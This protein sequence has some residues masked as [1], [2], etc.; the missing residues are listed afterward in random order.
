MRP[1]W[2]VKNFWRDPMSLCCMS[3]SLFTWKDAHLRKQKLNYKL[4]KTNLMRAVWILNNFR[5][6][7]VY[8]MKIFVILHNSIYTYANT[9]VT[10]TK[11][12]QQILGG[13]LLLVMI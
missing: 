9:S 7:C 13:K 4:K 3:K 10:L 12:S 2:T 6:C 11:I 1:L 5:G 8:S